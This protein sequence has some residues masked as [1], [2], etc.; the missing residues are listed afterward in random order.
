MS[1]D[2]EIFG[3]LASMYVACNKG[4]EETSFNSKFWTMDRPT[5]RQTDRQT[6]RLMLRQTDREKLYQK[7]WHSKLL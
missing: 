6:D 1:S 3:P 7:L 5:D 2:V 4:S